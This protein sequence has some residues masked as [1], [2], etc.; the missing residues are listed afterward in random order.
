[1]STQKENVLLNAQHIS[2]EKRTHTKRFT[3]TIGMIVHLLW[4]GF[5]LTLFYQVG[6]KYL[7]ALACLYYVYLIYSSSKMLDKKIQI[8]LYHIEIRNNELH[9]HFLRKSTSQSLTI[10]INNAY[11]RRKWH[12]EGRKGY[13]CLVF[14]EG[15]QERLTQYEHEDG[16]QT[17]WTRD[18]FIELYKKL[19]KALPP[20]HVTKEKFALL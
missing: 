19:E 8:E 1:M 16:D 11:V 7:T 20:G 12:R 10:P 3:L 5:L 14:C 9:L 17:V 13:F 6:H 18:S 15:E 4:I 2:W